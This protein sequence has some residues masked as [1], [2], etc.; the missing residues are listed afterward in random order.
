MEITTHWI[1]FQKKEKKKNVAN[2]FNFL[3]WLKLHIIDMVDI[4]TG[5]AQKYG[6]KEENPFREF[7][8]DLDV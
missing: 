5:P 1:S 2:T 3:N 7:S 6:Q 4:S 8:F